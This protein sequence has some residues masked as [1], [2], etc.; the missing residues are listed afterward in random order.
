[1]HVCIFFLSTILLGAGL[2]KYFISQR[3]GSKS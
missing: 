3:A 2:L 1:M